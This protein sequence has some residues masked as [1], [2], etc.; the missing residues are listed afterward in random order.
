MRQQRLRKDLDEYMSRRV[1]K[2]PKRSYIKDFFHRREF[3]EKH[4]TI[5]EHQ[6]QSLENSHQHDVVIVESE[7][8]FFKTLH[9]RIMSWFK[10]KK[11][12]KE[13]EQKS[14]D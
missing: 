5:S 8:N 9:D 11:K 1:V 10:D 2:E 14:K 7:P 6:I 4:M 12:S 3:S 13:K